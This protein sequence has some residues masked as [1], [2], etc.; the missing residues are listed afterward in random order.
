MMLREVRFIAS[1]GGFLSIWVLYSVGSTI[2]EPHS[3]NRVAMFCIRSGR[4]PDTESREN[5]ANGNQL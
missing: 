4:N 5:L 3:T 1:L 2:L